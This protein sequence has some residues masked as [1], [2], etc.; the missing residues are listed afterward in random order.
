MTDFKH[1]TPFQLSAYHN[2]SLEKKELNEIGKHLLMCPDCRKRLPLPSV[3]K[4][5][6]AI[7]T[8]NEPDE[9]LIDERIRFSFSS[10]FSAFSSFWN[11]HSNLVFGCAALV[12]FSSLSLFVWLN[13]SDTPK[14]VA[15]SYE[16][17]DDFKTEFETP[18]PNQT[19]TNNQD[20]LS[21]SKNAASGS[22][23]KKQNTNFP[24]SPVSQNKVSRNL[25]KKTP[26]EKPK[27]V[28]SATRGV[29]AKCGENR[30]VE[31]ELSLSK[32]NLVFK[33]KK[34]PGAAKYHLYISDDE[35]ILI[36]EYETTDETT[37]VL[38]KQLDPLK[39]YKWKIIITLENGQTVAGP[40][41]K[42]TVKDFQTNQ[43]KPEKKKNS[44]IR[45]SANG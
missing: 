40:S 33:W 15:Q 43:K 28:F 39:T 34:V 35:E 24:K 12:M 6:S 21:N 36:D 19:P 25:E 30:E 44:D 41:N 18:F 10:I 2:C 9:N 4:F 8:D 11:L 20:N 13:F 7:M 22:I 17:N 37:F 32:E 31:I 38:K 5:W 23:R 14:D 29:S 16:I 1:L 42:F 26:A 3:E 45:C 27:N